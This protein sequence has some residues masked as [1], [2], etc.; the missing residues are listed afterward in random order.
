MRIRRIQEI[1]D[2]YNR[3]YRQVLWSR[4]A[5]KRSSVIQGKLRRYD[6]YPAKTAIV[7]TLFT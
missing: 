7:V 4:G 5:N 1:H 2:S 6:I 3:G